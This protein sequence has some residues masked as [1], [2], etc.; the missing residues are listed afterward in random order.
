[1]RLRHILFGS[2]SAISVGLAAPA[3][4][5]AAPAA[6]QSGAD[7]D[8]PVIEEVVVTAERRTTDVQHTPLAITA[9]TGDSLAKSG[10][11]SA[12]DLVQRVPGVAINT[13][14]PQQNVFIRGVGG[15]VVNNFG[16]P[17]VAYNVDGVYIA[18]PYGGPSAA[19]YDLD[20]VEILKGPQGTLYGR[21][22][23]VG[24]VN[25]ITK[26][27]TFEKEGAV[28]FEFG[29]YND[30]QSSGMINLPLSDSVAV[31]FAFKSNK[32][33]GYL[34][35]G[36]NDA[37][38]FSARA[39]LLYKPNDAFSLRVTAD[40]FRDTSK[41][42]QSIFIY[43]GSNSQK[44]TDPG[45]PWFG[46]Q[47]PPCSIAI[48]CPVMPS[49]YLST[50]VPV[51]GADPSNDN[52]VYSLRGELTYNFGG[53]ELT[54]VPGLVISDIK[55]RFYTGGF[56]GDTDYYAKQYSLEARLASRG[57]GPLKWL[58][59]AF[60]YKEDQDAF[61]QFY[62]PQGYATFIVPNQIDKSW[63]LFGQATYSFTDRLRGTVGLRYTK[64]DKTQDG[65]SILPNVS[66]GL[67]TGAGGTVLPGPE[68]PQ[69]CQVSSVGSTSADNVSWK[70]GLEFDITPSSLLYANISTG[71]KA[72][73][74]HMGSAPNSY[75]PE[76]I[77]SYQ[78]GSK[79]R[80]FDNRLQ[81][82]GEVFYWDY[83]DQQI[84]TFQNIAPIGFASF[85]VNADGWLAGAELNSVFLLTSNDRFGLDVVYE[86]GQF[87]KY[88][89]PGATLH[90]PG[91]PTIV[92]S[93]AQTF[94]D[95]ERPAIPKW[96]GT[97]SYAHTFELSGGAN[98]VLEGNTHF[99]SG[100]WF[101]LAHRTNSYRGGYSL[102][103]VSLTYNDADHRWSATLFV[104]NVTNKAVIYGGSS[105]TYT[106]SAAYA[107]PNTDAWAVTI[108]PPRTFGIR[109][110]AKF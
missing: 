88:V 36:Y 29:N 80:F 96:N 51:G 59:G 19:F 55:G 40:Y 10:A 9:I 101:D 35:N 97:F 28:G 31:R 108:Y 4:A 26:A 7:N 37:D 78:I 65:V 100:A 49:S 76:R 52:K 79:N 89:N 32:H 98:F 64:E 25:V 61:N 63:A 15:G 38:S 22:A 93:P 60:L 86:R 110:S 66:A 45:N 74:L 12:T 85:P 109:I 48:Q 95:A 44:F 8:S 17:A 82:N 21:N 99:E 27:P 70:V 104:N 23:T 91:G 47:L 62:Q 58:L 50:L 46:T 39:S 42:Q 68:I 102:E 83:K 57:D 41:G 107:P 56:T 3:L 90:I 43:Q 67:C 84:Y 73:G 20:R 16:D 92:I 87:S 34:T 5:A 77:T 11:V 33:D 18:R 71:F 6:S 54:V 75:L 30:V 14:I 69:R 1:M 103:N 106:K 72:G 81:L 2:V 24:A 13:N 105:L 53:A 94:I